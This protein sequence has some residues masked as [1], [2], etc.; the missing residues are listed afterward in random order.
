MPDYTPSIS[1]DALSALLEDAPVRVASL[2]DLQ[3]L[4]ARLAPLDE[5]VHTMEVV[6]DGKGT[7]DFAIMGLDG[8]ED[9]DIPMEPVRMRALLDDK[10]AAMRAS[11]KS[12]TFELYFGETEEDPA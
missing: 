10:I 11:G 6:A 7:L 1:D 12:F 3:H 9:W 2:D 8:E 5:W 4:A